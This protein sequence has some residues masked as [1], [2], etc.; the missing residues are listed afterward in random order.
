[1][2]VVLVVVLPGAAPD[3]EGWAQAAVVASAAAKRARRIGCE[4][5]VM[6]AS[7]NMYF[8]WTA[9]ARFPLTV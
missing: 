5:R 9:A 7:W 6:A 8:D 3:V 4:V 2:L 1:V